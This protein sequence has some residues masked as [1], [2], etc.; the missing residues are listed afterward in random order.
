MVKTCNTKFTTLT[1]FKRTVQGVKYE[2]TLLLCWFTGKKLH[3]TN[4][5]TMM[6]NLS[7]RFAKKKK[8]KIFF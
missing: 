2:L 5:K 4:A 8:K 3:Q 1:I 7:S 6:K